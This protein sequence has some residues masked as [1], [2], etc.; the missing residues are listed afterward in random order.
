[1]NNIGVSIIML[2]LVEITHELVDWEFL[3]VES[4]IRGSKLQKTKLFCELVVGIYQVQ[5]DLHDSAQFAAEHE[6]AVYVIND[7]KMCKDPDENVMFLLD[8]Q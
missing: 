6:V 1:M 8:N 3:P 2:S 5:L 7:Q 4:T